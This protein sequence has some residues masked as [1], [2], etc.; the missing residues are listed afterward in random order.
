[1]LTEKLFTAAAVVGMTMLVIL[2]GKVLISGEMGLSDCL[3]APE[4]VRGW[5]SVSAHPDKHMVCGWQTAE[6]MLPV[7][8]C[9]KMRGCLP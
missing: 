8:R 4:V 9:L 6:A 2:M 3:E 5:H 7:F 1:M